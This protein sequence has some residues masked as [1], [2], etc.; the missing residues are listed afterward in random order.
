VV[1]QRLNSGDLTGYLL[2]NEDNWE[3]LVLPFRYDPKFI[4]KKSS[5]GF[6]DPRKIEG[7][8]IHPER[9]PEKTAQD[10]E[11]T[12]GSYHKN[13]QLQQN[14]EPRGG[15]IFKRDD[16]KF[17]KVLP[18][19]D[20]IVVSIDCTFKSL[21]TSDHVAIQAWGNKGAND[22]LL[23]GRVKERMGFG[24]TVTSLRTFVAAVTAK[25]P[26][27]GV[28]AVL[29]EDKANGSAVI[30]T[31]T[32]EIAGVLPINPEGGKAARAFAM[33][34]SCEA[35]NVWLPDPSVD[36]TIEEFISTCSKFTGAEGGD[37][38]EVDSMT[39]YCNW[40]RARS[41]TMGLVDYMKQQQEAKMKESA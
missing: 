31:L 36:P 6:Q 41:K 2:E 26:N 10:L 39:Q 16:W 32:D 18:E 13:A 40:R 24:A 7:E 14:P 17:W 28:T 21:S 4:P 20:E 19:F 34:P 9:I 1:H 25:Y 3:H 30:E 23:P 22:Y 38:D 11:K 29:V 37:D 27:V 12:L 33:Q 8:L 35:G 5:I 15:I